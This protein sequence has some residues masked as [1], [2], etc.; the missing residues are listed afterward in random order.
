M[1]CGD[2]ASVKAA[3]PF[4]KS[5]NARSAGLLIKSCLRPT[6]TANASFL[7]LSSRRRRRIGR[8]RGVERLVPGESK[9][10]FI[11]RV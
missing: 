4:E 11:N 10:S 9:H 2:E 7:T 5:A 8:A 1:G 3:I 6:Q